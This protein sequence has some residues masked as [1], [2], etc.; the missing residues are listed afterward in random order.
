MTIFQ[1]RRPR[2]KAREVKGY[3]RKSAHTIRTLRKK[4]DLTQED[5]AELMDVSQPAISTWEHGDHAPEYEHYEM[6]IAVG[7]S[8]GMKISVNDLK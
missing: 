3:N 8:V 2:R 7:E 1:R 6:I 5:F 4:A